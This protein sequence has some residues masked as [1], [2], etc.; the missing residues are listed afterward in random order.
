[1]ADLLGSLASTEVV[2]TAPLPSEQIDAT[3]LAP[4]KATEPIVSS[5][6]KWLLELLPTMHLLACIVA[7]SADKLNCFGE[8]CTAESL[9]CVLLE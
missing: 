3:V 4:E 6:G 1:M 8:G 9:N 2:K 7:V 5:D